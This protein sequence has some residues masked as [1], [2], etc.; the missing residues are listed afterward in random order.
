M[1]SSALPHALTTPPFPYTTL[2]RSFELDHAAVHVLAGLAQDMHDVDGA[3]RT[4]SHQHELHRA[5]AEIL[6]AGLGRRIDDDRVAAAALGDKRH[7]LDE[8]DARLHV[9]CG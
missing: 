4:G 8:L 7:A 2:F 1:P 3:A 6:S 5:R 9:A